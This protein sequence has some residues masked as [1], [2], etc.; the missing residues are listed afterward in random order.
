MFSE[1]SYEA[2]NTFMKIMKLM[3]LLFVSLN[4]ISDFQFKIGIE[5]FDEHFKLKTGFTSFYLCFNQFTKPDMCTWTNSIH[6][7]LNPISI[8]KTKKPCKNM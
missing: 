4:V 8:K 6:A 7:R 3:K 5:Y 1:S 2:Y